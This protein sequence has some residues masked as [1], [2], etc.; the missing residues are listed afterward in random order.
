VQRDP[1][2][3]LAIVAA[4]QDLHTAG[5]DTVDGTATSGFAGTATA[6]VTF[7]NFNSPL[8]IKPPV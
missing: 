7:T 8:E 4:V 2:V 1:G 5:Q 6:T 3:L